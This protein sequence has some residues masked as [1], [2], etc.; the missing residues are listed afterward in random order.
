[1]TTNGLMGH[2]SE[3]VESGLAAVT[4]VEGILEQPKRVSGSYDSD[5]FEFKLSEAV[6][7]AMKAEQ[8]LIEL[9]DDEFTGWITYAKPGAEPTPQGGFTRGWCKSA[10]KLLIAQGMAE[11]EIKEKKAGWRNFIGQRVTVEKLPIVY[12]QTVKGGETKETE[13]PSWQFVEGDGEAEGNMDDY[14]KSLVVGKKLEVARRSILIDAKAKR[15]PEYKD[16]LVDG[17]LAEML[18]LEVDEDGKFQEP[19]IEEEK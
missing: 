7:L 13:Y 2:S 1:M 15:Y 14:I 18:G 11:E 9:K 3:A 4:K 16:A 10:E 12:K 5:Q 17:T 19:N 8:E 6:V